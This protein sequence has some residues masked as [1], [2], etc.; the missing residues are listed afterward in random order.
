MLMGMTQNVPASNYC[1]IFEN[2]WNGTKMTE[3]TFDQP[4]VL[5][6]KHKHSETYYV[7]NSEREVLLAKAQMVRE[8]DQNSMFYAPDEPYLAPKDKEI[9]ILADYEI[10]NLPEA[11]REA[12]KS[13][14]RNIE[15]AQERF[16]MEQKD[17][18]VLRNF[19][20]AESIEDAIAL[21]APDQRTLAVN[22]IVR[23]YG[24]HEYTEWDLDNS[25]SLTAWN[26]R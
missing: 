11:F 20:S 22:W 9:G 23:T 6:A 4:K 24:G 26:D 10:A 16:L 1:W 17:F 15:R 14:R 5:I 12:A 25:Y 7:V 13:A 3:V 19:L 2:D 21:V 18:A 8:W